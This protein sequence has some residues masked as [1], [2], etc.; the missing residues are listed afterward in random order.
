MLICALL[1]EY[2]YLQYSTNTTGIKGKL[3]NQTAHIM[4][5]VN[6]AFILS[7]CINKVHEN[8]KI[9]ESST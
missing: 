2:I 4:N 7:I 3:F 9:Y 5:V 1:K 8:L 6:F